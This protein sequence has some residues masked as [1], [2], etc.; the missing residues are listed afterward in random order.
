MQQHAIHSCARRLKDGRESSIISELFYVGVEHWT[1]LGHTP[2]NRKTAQGVYRVRIY[3][4][5]CT[6]SKY[7]PNSKIQQNYV[8]WHHNVYIY[9]QQQEKQRRNFSQH[10]EYLIRHAAVGC[11]V[12]TKWRGLYRTKRLCYLCCMCVCMYGSL[13]GEGSGSSS[14]R[15]NVLNTMA[16]KMCISMRANQRPGH[17]YLPPPKPTK[18]SRNWFLSKSHWS[19]RSCC[20]RNPQAKLICN[21]YLV[22]YKSINKSY[23]LDQ[24]SQGLGTS[25]HSCDSS[26][27]RALTDDQLGLCTPVKEIVNV[28]KKTLLKV[29]GHCSCTC[30]LCSWSK[31]LLTVKSELLFGFLF[32]RHPLNIIHILG[33]RISH[34]MQHWWTITKQS[35][36]HKNVCQEM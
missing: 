4:A 33:D 31:I 19:Q 13:T 32:M 5:P 14:S 12:P 10:L 29:L 16:T 20:L 2:V 21:T 15:S 30:S 9:K 23:V 28:Q 24:T 25:L 27:E 22:V 3:L 17:W 36:R 8:W 34:T 11:W 1:A 18:P 35:N 26:K 6:K 7:I